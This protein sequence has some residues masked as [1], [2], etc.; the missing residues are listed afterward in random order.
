MP[1]DS[2]WCV[3]YFPVAFLGLNLTLHMKSRSMDFSSNAERRDT[4]REIDRGNE[5][6]EIVSRARETTSNGQF[7]GTR[8]P[9]APRVR[10]LLT[11]GKPTRFIGEVFKRLAW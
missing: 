2:I 10:K 5:P 11:H 4:E 6:V 3:V 8:T 9:I 1:A 7:S